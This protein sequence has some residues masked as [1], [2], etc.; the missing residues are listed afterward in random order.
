M[1]YIAIIS[2][3]LGLVLALIWLIQEISTVKLLDN[4]LS[5]AIG[6][7]LLGSTLGYFAKTKS[8]KN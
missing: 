3:T 5:G 2:M 8:D 4:P 6:F 1:K 7:S